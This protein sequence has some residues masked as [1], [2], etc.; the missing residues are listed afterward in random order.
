MKMIVEEGGENTHY[1]LELMDVDMP[2]G[3]VI[4]WSWRICNLTIKFDRPALLTWQIIMLMWNTN[5]LCLDI[6]SHPF[7]YFVFIIYYY[8]F[9]FLSLLILFMWLFCFLSRLHS[10]WG[11]I[12]W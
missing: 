11:K 3:L 7:Q 2:P 5:C 8:C 12:K 4:G 1:K 6:V 9:F 10:D